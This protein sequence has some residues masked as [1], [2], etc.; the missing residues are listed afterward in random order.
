MNGH[1][2]LTPPT[3]ATMSRA[4]RFLPVT[5]A[6]LRALTPAPAPP[7]PAASPRWMH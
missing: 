1:A 4:A 7:Q 6:M 3:T 2:E 5:L